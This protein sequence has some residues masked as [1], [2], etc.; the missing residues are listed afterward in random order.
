MI[1]NGFPMDSKGFCLG[2]PMDSQHIAARF[3]F[4][5]WPRFIAQAMMTHLRFSTS[6]E[7]TALGGSED[8]ATYLKEVD[9]Q[10]L[11][12]IGSLRIRICPENL[13]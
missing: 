10:G 7:W 3:V 13:P 6:S 8:A 4:F 9:T 5:P 2:F 1:P 12:S 11:H